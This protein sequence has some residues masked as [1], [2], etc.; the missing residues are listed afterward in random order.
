MGAELVTIE[1]VPAEAVIELAKTAKH[2]HLFVDKSLPHLLA[3]GCRSEFVVIDG[4]H[5]WFTVYNELT[6]V[7]RSWEERHAT[8]TIVLHDVGW[9]SGRRDSYCDPAAIPPEALHPYSFAQGVTVG[10]PGLI[11]GGFR[12]EGSF[13]WALREGGP[14]NGVLTAI[15]DFISDNPGWSF[16][17]VSAVFGLGVLTRTGS[18][19]DAIAGD[20]ICRY[21]TA[22]VNRL[23]QNRLALYLKVIEL[24]DELARQARAR[25][26][27][28]AA[29]AA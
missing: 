17:T 4:D 12:G 13:A 10:E 22:L 19:E 15:E 3:H 29:V 28:K 1:P 26:Q 16:R 7:A 8:G 11:D 21:D 23:E 18:V 6:L 5:N 24:Q 27:E 20:V 25:E 9:P 2:F 14:C